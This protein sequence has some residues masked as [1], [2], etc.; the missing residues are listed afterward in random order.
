MFQ[1]ENASILSSKDLLQGLGQ[2]MF[3]C[4]HY[5]ND[6]TFLYQI[7]NGWE[8]IELFTSHHSEKY[9]PYH[10]HRMITSSHNYGERCFLV[11]SFRLLCRFLV[12]VRVWSFEHHSFYFLFLQLFPEI[13]SFLLLSKDV[14]WTKIPYV[15]PSTI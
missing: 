4:E 6:S 9:H 15:H 5:T 8:H 1:F 11:I 10:H 2:L 7:S 3:L 14:L 13:I 12:S